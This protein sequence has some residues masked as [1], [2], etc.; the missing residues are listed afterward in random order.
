MT[1]NMMT[2]TGGDWTFSVLG[3]CSMAWMSFALLVFLILIIRRQTD[4]GFLAGVGFNFIGALVGGLGGHI[5]LT[6][7]FGSARWAMLG[8]FAGLIVGGFVIGMFL[9]SGGGYE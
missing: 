1:Y 3:A 7:L 5:V 8:G 9:D 2:C 6:T 4:D